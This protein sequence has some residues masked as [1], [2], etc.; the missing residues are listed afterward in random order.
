MGCYIEFLI[1]KEKILEIAGKEISMPVTV[2]C[3]ENS[4]DFNFSAVVCRGFSPFSQLYLRTYYC[5]YST[6]LPQNKEIT[7]QLPTREC[8]LYLQES[9]S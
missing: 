2:H 9:R 5:T 1:L 3:S 6:L 4:Y 7:T 8:E